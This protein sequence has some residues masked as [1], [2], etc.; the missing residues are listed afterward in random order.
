MRK[1]NDK[2][3][4]AEDTNSKEKTKRNKTLSL[5]S[6]NIIKKNQHYLFCSLKTYNIKTYRKEKTE[7]NRNK[8]QITLS[9]SIAVGESDYIL[10]AFMDNEQV[11]KCISE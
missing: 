3:T 2:H 8:T 6:Q 10:K 5:V 1:S 9:K 7:T 11:N 4:N